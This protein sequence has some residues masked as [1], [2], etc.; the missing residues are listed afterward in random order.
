M[1]LRREGRAVRLR[2]ALPFPHR[3]LVLVVGHFGHIFQGDGLVQGG[4]GDGD[5]RLGLGDAG[6]QFLRVGQHRARVL[7]GL[8]RAVAG[9]LGLGQERAGPADVVRMGTGPGAGQLGLRHLHP[10]LRHR[11][12]R[13]RDAVVQADQ[14]LTGLHRVSLRHQHLGDA[15]AD[16]RC[17]RDLFGFNEAGGGE[18]PRCRSGGPNAG[19]G[20]FPK[21]GER[22]MTAP[23]ASR[24][25]SRITGISHRRFIAWHSVVI[26]QDGISALRASHP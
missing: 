11:D 25:A 17:N 2:D 24:T 9:G 15:P 1:D 10:G 8:V 3:G 12:L 6:V 5:L 4:A 13:P 7:P 19:Q 26:A 21:P 16:L 14:D 23:A 20:L 18:R 22:A